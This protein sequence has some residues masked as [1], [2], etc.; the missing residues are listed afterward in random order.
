MNP[1]SFVEKPTVLVVDDAP[2]VIASMTMLLKDKYLVK[3]ATN[4]EKALK[5]ALTGPPP[6]LILLDIMMPHIDG[7]EVCRRLKE[8]RNLK[9]VPVIFISA[10]DA[11]EDII[12]GFQVGGVDYITKPFQPEE[13]HARVSTHLHLHFYRHELDRK[14]RQLEDSYRNLQDMERLRD[15]LVH[16][17]VHDMRN[18][19]MG[20]YA[21]MEMLTAH[22]SGAL[23]EKGSMYLQRAARLLENLTEMI[24]TLLDVNKMETKEMAMIMSEFDLNDL[25]VEAMEK[26]EAMRE[27]RE[28]SFSRPNR[29]LPVE[30]DRNILLRIIIN[31]LNNAIKFTD[32]DGRIVLGTAMEE[33][34]ACF[35]INDNG[36]GI[37][38]AYHEKIFDKFGQVEIRQR[39][40]KYSTGLGLTFC[41]LGIEAHKGKIWVDSDAGRG[42]TFL[43][44]IPGRQ[45][46]G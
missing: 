44:R 22:S 9:Q 16:M 40:N 27:D 23:D 2:E 1:G 14:N 31:L 46:R 21:Y 3:V 35:S 18:L 43:F 30:G 39:G 33:T 38:V 24:N 10:L 15:N 25:V 17:V 45:N 20:V 42:S 13:V 37:P 19:L 12:K 7:Y 28:I 36:P 26:L 4:G 11:T 34:D 8:D 29:P 6:D 32:V 41:K 5:V